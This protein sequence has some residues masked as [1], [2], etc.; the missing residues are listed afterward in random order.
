MGIEPF[1]LSSSV[2]G[3]LAQRLVRQLCEHCKEP[4]EANEQE[5]QLLNLNATNAP[6]IF[7]AKGCDE[8]NFQ[9]YRGRTGIYDLLF[10]NEEIR[11]AIHNGVAESAIEKM[12]R[13][14][15]PSIRANGRDQV[16]AG[17]T[18]VE[19]VLRVTRED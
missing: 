4:R 17:L 13:E 6:T 10:V 7:T 16:L 8:C 11:D 19:E 1:L 18:T 12:A 15:S 3:V 14:F 9:G 2:L 5:V